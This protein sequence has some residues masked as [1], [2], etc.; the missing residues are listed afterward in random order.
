M[1]QSRQ[2]LSRLGLQLRVHL[3]WG[4]TAGSGSGA[5]EMLLSPPSAWVP[6]WAKVKE[7][8][9][10]SRGKWLGWGCRAGKETQGR[11]QR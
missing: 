5:E 3:D 4:G 6:V 2:V 1:L 10:N 9:W 11:G 7:G 8:D